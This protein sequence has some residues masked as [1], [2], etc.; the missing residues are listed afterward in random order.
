MFHSGLAKVVC[1][2]GEYRERHKKTE[3]ER[4][5]DTHRVRESHRE[6][7]KERKGEG[8]KRE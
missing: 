8:R 1:P 3:R 6:T 4:Q 7:G 2:K 5:F